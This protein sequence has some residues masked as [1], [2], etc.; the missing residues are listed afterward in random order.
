M[1]QLRTAATHGFYTGVEAKVFLMRILNNEEDPSGE[2]LPV[3]RQLA[4]EYPE[5][6]YFQRYHAFLAFGQGEFVDCER[7]SKAILNGLNRGLPGY[8]GT[9]GRY[10]AYFLGYLMDHRYGDVAQAKNYYQRCIVSSES[11]GDTSGGFY[12]FTHTN[13][14]RIAVREKDLPTARRYYA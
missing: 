1:N 5:N 4:M 13:M 3:A 12:L 2:A 14:A 11:T 7:T 6:A 9:S 8:E 10:A